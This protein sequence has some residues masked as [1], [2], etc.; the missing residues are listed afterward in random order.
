[1]KSKASHDMLLITAIIFFFHTSH[2]NLIYISGINLSLK[3]CQTHKTVIRTCATEYDE[4][5][6]DVC[7]C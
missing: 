6:F 1:M 2:H 5:S 7:M 3:F 4:N